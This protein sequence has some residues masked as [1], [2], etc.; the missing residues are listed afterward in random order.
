MYTIKSYVFPESL[1]EAD[2]LL[3]RDCRSSAILGGCCWLKMGHRRIRW[4]IS[5]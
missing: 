3:R 1:E 4:A 5:I 2:E